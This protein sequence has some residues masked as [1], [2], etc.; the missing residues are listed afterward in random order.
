MTREEIY[1]KA[2]E[3]YLKGVDDLGD[4]YIMGYK[5]ISDALK[6]ASN[7]KDGPSETDKKRIRRIEK[8]LWTRNDPL[9][10][11]DI[12]WEHLKLMQVWGME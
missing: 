3:E 2:L 5:I 7:I 11:D 10:F 8:H 4:E 6:Q 1:K 12:A 9:S